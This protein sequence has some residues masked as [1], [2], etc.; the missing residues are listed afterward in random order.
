VNPLSWIPLLALSPLSILTI[1]DFGLKLKKFWD[2]CTNRLLVGLCQQ[3]EYW[4][5]HCRLALAKFVLGIGDAPGPLFWDPKTKE[6][7][8]LGPRIHTAY[9]NEWELKRVKSSE[10]SS[11]AS[12]EASSGAPSGASSE[13]SSGASSV[14]NIKERIALFNQFAN[15]A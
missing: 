2:M 12:S 1:G 3:K 8:R 14:S 11:E 4:L 6:V 7:R 9:V 5:S 15:A 10:V 13:A